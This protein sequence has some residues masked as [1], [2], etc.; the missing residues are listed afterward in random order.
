MPLVILDEVQKVPAIMDAVQSLIDDQIAYFILTGSSARKLKRHKDIN[1]LPGRVTP[2]RMDPLSITEVDVQAIQLESLLLNGSLPAVFAAVGVDQKELLLNAYVSIYLEE[3][4]R[5]EALVRNLAAFSRFL[6]LAAS[7][8]GYTVNY[9]K[10]AQTVGVTRTTIAEYYQ[11]LVDCLVAERIEPYT[12][13][14]TRHKLCK[15]SKYLLFD[16]GV[17][18]V[19]A[20]EGM[21]MSPKLLGHLFEQFVGLECIRLLRVSAQRAVL[22][23]W[24]DLDGPEVDWLICHEGRMIPIEVKYTDHPSKGDCKHLCAFLREYEEATVAY[25]VCRAARKM[26][27]ADNVYAIPWQ[28][29]DEI[30]QL[31]NRD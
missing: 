9:S 7:E 25:V 3:E 10:L 13:S 23:Y 22:H 1:L 28:Q 11:I 30:I 2:L 26:K 24:K 27:L 29:L 18:R 20:R 4:V 31:F 19:A 5:S 17:R 16:L 12:K 8:S 21:H 6:E 15:S 14:K